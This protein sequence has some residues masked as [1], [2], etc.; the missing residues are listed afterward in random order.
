MTLAAEAAEYRK[1]QAM[2]AEEHGLSGTALGQKVSVLQVD[3][4]SFLADLEAAG[5]STSTRVKKTFQSYTSTHSNQSQ[6]GSSAE[7]LCRDRVEAGGAVACGAN[8]Y[9]HAGIRV[10]RPS[11]R[12]DR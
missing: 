1:T 10:D 9:S 12:H 8:S 7:A 4:P 3:D 11:H 2:L 6:S 5:A